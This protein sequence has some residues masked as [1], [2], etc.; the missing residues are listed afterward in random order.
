M[1]HR[2][3]WRGVSRRV[4]L[5]AGLSLAAALLRHSPRFRPRPLQAQ[6]LTAAEVPSNWSLKPA[7]LGAG[8][9][10]RLLFL[11]SQQTANNLTSLAPS[12]LGAAS[13]ADG[14]LLEWQAA[15]AE[16]DSVTDYRVT[17]T[18]VGAIGGEDVTTEIETG[19]TDPSYLDAGATVLG[20][21]YRYQVRALRG[22]AA[23]EAS[24]EVT[25]FYYGDDASTI[26]YIPPETP[27][28][29]EPASTVRHTVT[30]ERILVSNQ[31]LIGH[32]PDIL[33]ITVDVRQVI[34]A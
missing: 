22:A 4:R 25:A 14:I 23:S 10:F 3:F 29:S 31:G 11:S 16:A 21:I 33:S 5:L 19:S 13:T 30:D 28:S 27:K 6:S 20:G 9:K 12:S 32:V 1:P 34:H 8:D 7:D 18:H 15:A 2:R 17:R 24:N 26:R